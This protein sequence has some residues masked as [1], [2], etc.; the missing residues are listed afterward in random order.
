MMRANNDDF[1]E[2]RQPETKDPRPQQE[3][4]KKHPVSTWPFPSTRHQPRRIIN[5]ASGEDCFANASD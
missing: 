1:Y 2:A 4:V 5:I 3:E